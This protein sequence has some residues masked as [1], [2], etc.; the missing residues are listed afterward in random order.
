M[1]NVLND[2]HRPELDAAVLERVLR[3][4]RGEPS[5]VRLEPD[6]FSLPTRRLHWS[7]GLEVEIKHQQ[8]GAQGA[9][10]ACAG[11]P[12]RPRCTEG[13]LALRLSH[14]GDLRPCMDRP[15][16]SVSLRS[17]MAHEGPGAVEA[18]LRRLASPAL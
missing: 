8:L 11:C 5:L 10:Q 9:Y 4:L 2:L 14:T 12:E 15:D 3:A 7:D 18:L 16:L 6:P 17:V 1:V 13:I